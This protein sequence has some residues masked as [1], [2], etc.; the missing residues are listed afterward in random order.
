M[1]KTNKKLSVTGN[2]RFNRREAKRILGILRMI[3]TKDFHDNTPV[4]L[5]QRGSPVK[6]RSDAEV[7]KKMNLMRM[8]V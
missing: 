7:Y 5:V 4:P 3:M 8:Q 6:G 1:R 2:R